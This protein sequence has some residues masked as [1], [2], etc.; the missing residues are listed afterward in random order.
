MKLS[1]II[2]A[3]KTNMPVSIF[4]HDDEPSEQQVEAAARAWLEWTFPARDW[5]TAPPAMR[6]KF[7]E[8]ARASL[9]AAAA[10]GTVPSSSAASG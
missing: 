6:D 2:S 5:N 10:V 7:R 8:G 3:R 9:R 4:L 1:R